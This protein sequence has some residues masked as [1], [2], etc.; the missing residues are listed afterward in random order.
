MIHVGSNFAAFTQADKYS[1]IHVIKCVPYLFFCIL[2][3]FYHGN[4]S[5]QEQT[6]M[7]ILPVV[8]R[9]ISGL[10]MLL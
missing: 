2:A 4:I 9:E 10:T 6:C 7:C 1:N 5:V 8:K 3:D